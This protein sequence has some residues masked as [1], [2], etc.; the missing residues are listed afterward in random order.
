MGHD[1]QMC[2]EVLRPHIVLLEFYRFLNNCVYACITPPGPWNIYDRLL[3]AEFA[4]SYFPGLR[5]S[6]G[7]PYPRRYL[8]AHY[9]SFRFPAHALTFPFVVKDGGED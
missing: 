5:H 8:R 9:S 6:W 1:S 4:T 3:K 2:S 7:I